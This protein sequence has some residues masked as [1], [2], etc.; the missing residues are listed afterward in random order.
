MKGHFFL[1]LLLLVILLT[2]PIS[3]RAA[4]DSPSATNQIRTVAR[5]G[6]TPVTRRAVD[7]LI[8]NRIS[9]IFS[10]QAGSETTRAIAR[11][12]LIDR[13][14]VLDYLESQT[15]MPPFDVKVA[16]KKMEDQLARSGR[17][18]DLWL[19]QNDQ[20]R[21]DLEL[22]MRWRHHWH[23]YTQKLLTN[24]SQRQKAFVRWGFQFDGSKVEVA[25]I[26]L[27]VNSL[28][29]ADKLQ[30]AT[31]IHNRLTK[32][33]VSIEEVWK[34]EVL[35]HSNSPNRGSASPNSSS[36]DGYPGY[37]GWIEYAY[38]MPP[39]F[40]EQ[41]FSHQPREFSVPFET[42]LGIH[43]VRVLNRQPGDR[44]IDQCQKKLDRTMQREAFQEILKRHRSKVPVLLN[45][46]GQSGSD[47]AAR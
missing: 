46:R 23:L 41:V 18:L 35:A 27:K 20:H 10:A 4:Q 15:G 1:L 22:E 34:A 3:G 37:V 43:I 14:I 5:V 17:T 21:Q 32:A 45:G 39:R 44:T 33:D 24:E 28:N 8:A 19:T 6:Q 12:H 26:L 2:V 38:P 30:L 42:G 36:S 9:G 29:R 25:Q 47:G 11:Q 7:R 31:E 16:I 40:A 13:T